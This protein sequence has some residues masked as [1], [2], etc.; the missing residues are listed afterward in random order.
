MNKQ[1]YWT[2]DFNELSVQWENEQNRW[3]MNANF[4]ERRKLIFCWMIEQ[5]KPNVSF[6]N[7]K[8]KKWKKSWMRPSLPRDARPISC[9]NWANVGSANIGQW[10]ISS[11]RTSLYSN[12]QLSKKLWIMKLTISNRNSVELC[13][14]AQNRARIAR[15]CLKWLRIVRNCAELCSN[16]EELCEFARNCQ[17]LRRTKI[18][19]RWKPRP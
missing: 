6:T 17:E 15:N 8:R 5:K 18:H 1:F 10:P 4:W 19:L 14:I 16:F 3:K 2:N 12:M 11:W 13:G 9:E 7:N